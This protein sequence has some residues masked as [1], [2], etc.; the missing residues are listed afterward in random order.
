VDRRRFLTNSVSMTAAVASAEPAA[1]GKISLREKFFGCI[2]GAHLGSAFGAPVEG[3]SYEDIEKKYGTV[4]RLY[5]YQHHNNGW[6]RAAGTTEDGV[7][8]QKLMITAIIEKKDRVTAEDVRKIWVRDINPES[9]AMIVTAFEPVLVQMAKSGIPANDL[10][11]YCDFAGLNAFARAC[12]PIGLINAGDLEGAVSDV[13]EVG[14]LYQTSNSRGLQ[15]AACTGIA[16]AAATKPNATVDSV[17][18]AVLDGD[19]RFA[20]PVG[21]DRVKAEI[22]RGLKATE[23]CQDFR[24]LRKALRDIYSTKGVTYALASAPEVVVRGLCAFR[25]VK[26]VLKDAMIA[27]ANMGRDTD[28]VTAV[29]SGISGA[30]SGAGS[31]PEEW[32]KQADNAT[33]I[34][35]YTNNKRTLR[36]SSDG[37][38]EAYRARLGRMRAFAGQMEEA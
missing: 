25:M 11:R 5:P 14:Q 36:Q 24:E 28:C 9:V 26:G 38:Y 6:D 7:E 23:K 3:W 34:N 31:I 21:G 30:L 37:L 10:G 22:E 16:I 17:I 35:P 19:P 12:H 2:V 8:R 32:I 33:N 18:G 27:G 29:A 1:T 15:W 13:F 4:D 20:K